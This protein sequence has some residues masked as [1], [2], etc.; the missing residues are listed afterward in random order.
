MV[1]NKEPLGVESPPHPLSLHIQSSIMFAYQCVEKLYATFEGLH[2][3]LAALENH[4]ESTFRPH[5][6][7]PVEVRWQT[8]HVYILV[9]VLL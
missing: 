3:Q 2:L 4:F 8:L 1:G 6:E 5:T 9:L 7:A